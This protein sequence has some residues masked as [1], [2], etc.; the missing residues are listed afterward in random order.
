MYR[1][2][3]NHTSHGISSRPLQVGLYIWCKGTGSLFIKEFCFAS[4]K[5]GTLSAVKAINTVRKYLVKFGVS[6]NMMAA[7]NSLE[8][9]VSRVHHRLKKQ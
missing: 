3:F 5:P 9:E 8:S 4:N 2:F 6:N 7:L 1:I